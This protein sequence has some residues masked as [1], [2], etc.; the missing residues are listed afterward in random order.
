[1]GPLPGIYDV[2]KRGQTAIEQKTREPSRAR[3]D[4]RKKPKF[5]E[6]AAADEFLHSVA[7]IAL[8]DSGDGGIDGDDER[9]K[10]GEAGAFNRG[11][12]G[13]AA[14]HQIE[15]I[16]DGSGRGGFYVFQLVSRY[17]GENVGGARIAGG[18]S[19]AHFAHGVHEAAVAD[20]SEQEWK[21][22]IE[23]ENTSAQVA[24]GDG[25]RMAGAE[26]DVLI[27]AAIFAEGDLA[28]G[29]AIKVIEDRSGH[30]ALGEGAEIRDADHAG[31]GD[32]AGGSSHSVMAV[33]GV[34]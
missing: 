5:F 7:V 21:S 25:D 31:R 30:A 18:A 14:T 1:M 20:R 29:A 11:L 16:E 15:L 34:R 6:G 13:G 33:P 12:G 8:A 22:E 32:G 24:I 2:G 27:D 3:E 10:S 23:A 26:G 19:G 17:G 28:F 9:G 4:L